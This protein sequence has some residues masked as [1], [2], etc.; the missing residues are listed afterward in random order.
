MA[1]ADR[2]TPQYG[3]S[4]NALKYIIPYINFLDKLPEKS[5]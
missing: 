2:L 3:A 1:L 5:F 4:T